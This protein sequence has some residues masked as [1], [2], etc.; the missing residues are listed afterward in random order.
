MPHRILD[1]I[2]HVEME[3]PGDVRQNEFVELIELETVSLRFVV[4]L[5]RLRFFDVDHARDELRLVQFGRDHE[6]LEELLL[7]IELVVARI[8]EA[9]APAAEVPAF[10]F[11]EDLL[12]DLLDVAVVC[13]VEARSVRGRQILYIKLVGTYHAEITLSDL[14]LLADTEFSFLPLP[15]EGVSLEEFD[16]LIW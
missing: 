6:E 3:L 10:K 7:A 5:F 12:L 2:V 9:D 13:K 4:Q 15:V 1:L 14:V 11:E 8:D 16:L